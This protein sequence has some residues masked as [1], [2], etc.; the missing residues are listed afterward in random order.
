MCQNVSTREGMVQGVLT[1]EMIH[2]FDYCKNKLDFRNMDHLACTEIRAANLTHCSFMSA[3]SQGDAYYN[4]V[5][6]THEVCIIA[7]YNPASLTNTINAKV[8]MSGCLWLNH[9]LTGLDETWRINI[10][11]SQIIFRRWWTL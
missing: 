10:L 4:K 3:W 11:L 1:H 2:M 5:A 8:L 7:Y 6:K 9:V